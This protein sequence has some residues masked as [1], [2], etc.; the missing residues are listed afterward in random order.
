MIRDEDE[1]PTSP[2]P[3]P[4]KAQLAVDKPAPLQVQ[5]FTHKGELVVSFN[6]PVG[7]WFLDSAAL[8]QF[9]RVFTEEAA[10]LEIQE[11]GQ[12]TKQ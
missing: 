8:R 5:C 2:R 4:P 11:A 9:A 12:A 1:K 10:Q 6:Q 3:A 7:Q